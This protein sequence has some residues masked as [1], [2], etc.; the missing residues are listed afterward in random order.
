MYPAYALRDFTRSSTSAV[1]VE[2][3]L[4]MS[5]LVSSLIDELMSILLVTN[6]GAFKLDADVRT[7]EVRTLDILPRLFRRTREITSS[8]V[9]RILTR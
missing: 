6:S 3:L 4:L 8:T 1:R 7:D 5:C 2:N 9:S